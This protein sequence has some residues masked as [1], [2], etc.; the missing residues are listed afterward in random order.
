ML[1]IADAAE[2]WFAHL[3]RLGF[4]E[5][6]AEV[7]AVSWLPKSVQKD[8]VPAL[9]R[10][11]DDADHSVRVTAAREIAEIRDVSAEALPS[12]IKSFKRENG[13]EGMEYAVESG[14]GGYI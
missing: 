1:A 5:R 13:E 8:R 11:L 14:I 12:L 10:L 7:R 3:N 2:D 6:I 4:W 9:T